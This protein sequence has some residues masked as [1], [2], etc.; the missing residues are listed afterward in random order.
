MTYGRIVINYCPEK[1]DP[2][3][4]RLTVGS[5][6]IN[7]PGDYGTPTADMITVKMLLNSVM[8]TKGAKFMS[9]YIKNFYL[10]TPM[11]QYEYMRL[12]IT[13]LPQ[14]F[15]DEY[16]GPLRTQRILRMS[17]GAPATSKGIHH[18][19]DLPSIKPAI[20]YL[21]TAAGFPMN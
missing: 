2:N 8:S 9:I 1:R 18:V 5:D 6:V 7:C 12:K 3:R 20:R 17:D 10:N 13:E 19:S 14:D 15:I 16:N 4:V 21:H 11:A